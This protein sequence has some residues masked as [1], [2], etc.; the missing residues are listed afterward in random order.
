MKFENFNFD[1][2][3][4]YGAIILYGGKVIL[5]IILLLIGLKVIKKIVKIADNKF[6]KFNFDKSLRPFLL[7]L[8]KVSLK[9]LLLITIASMF[10]V[11]TTSFIA[12]IGSAGLAIGLALQGS[13]SNFAGGILIL[14]LKPF[15][16]GDYIEGA[17]HAGT[18]EEI[19]I[20]YTIL[21]TPDNKRVIIPNANLSN[22]STINYSTNSTRRVDFVFGVG[23]EDD[24]NKVK[25]ILRKIASEHPLILQDPSPQVVLGEYDASAI[26]FFFRVWAK[27][28][29][30]WKIYYD[31]ME[32]VKV[33]FDNEQINIPYPQMDIH[34]RKED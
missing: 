31:V 21:T 27:N 16:I 28:E 22:S 5:S 20:F 12:V 1:F 29:D 3:G 14:I 7:S 34:I 9:V 4:L 2:E 33:E 25:E 18:I 23:Y 11:Q 8:I 15:K 10:G 6:E 30:Y 26:N 32:Q 19:Q 24:M 13:L 17:G